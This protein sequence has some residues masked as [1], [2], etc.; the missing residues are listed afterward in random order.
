VAQE[1]ENILGTYSLRPNQQGGGAH[2]ANCGYMT[3]SHATGRG[4]AS[5]MAEHSLAYAKTRGFSAM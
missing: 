3:A 1:G 2:V 5:A 4:V